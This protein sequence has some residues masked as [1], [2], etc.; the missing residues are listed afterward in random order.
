MQFMLLEMLVLCGCVIFERT[1]LPVQICCYA[2][3]EKVHIVKET[4]KSQMIETSKRYGFP[5]VFLK[6]L[7]T[8]LLFVFINCNKN[9]TLQR[10][11]HHG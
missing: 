9:P 3:K 10:K 7:H 11:M 2:I 6:V 5:N 1:L 4:Q 8:S